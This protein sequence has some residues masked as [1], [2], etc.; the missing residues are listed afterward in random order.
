MYTHA[1]PT[2]RVTPPG[3]QQTTCNFMHTAHPT[4]SRANMQVTARARTAPLLPAPG[5]LRWPHS[6]PSQP[7]PVSPMLA[8][9]DDAPSTAAVQ[10][11]VGCNTC[12]HNCADAARSRQTGSRR[13]LQPIASPCG[14]DGIGTMGVVGAEDNTRAG[15]RVERLSW[16]TRGAIRQPLC[17][18]VHR[19][20]QHA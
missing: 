18:P 14:G 2:C 8:R 6:S 20:A 9:D 3:Q 16:G 13:L 11:R 1:T 19:A 7:H 12:T 17:P 5:A 15:A 10:Q 4:P